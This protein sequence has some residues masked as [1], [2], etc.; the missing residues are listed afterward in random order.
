MLSILGAAEGT[1]EPNSLLLCFY[2]G[3]RET[4]IGRRN[5]DTGGSCRISAI[6]WSMGE[7]ES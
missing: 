1:E 5:S 7:S 6:I 2:S 3:G 4:D